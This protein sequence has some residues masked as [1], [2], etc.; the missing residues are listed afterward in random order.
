MQFAE[1]ERYDLT[2]KRLEIIRILDF[3]FSFVLC[4]QEETRTATAKAKARATTTGRT[5]KWEQI[6][7][8]ERESSNQCFSET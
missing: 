5:E 7:R 1:R 6:E 4:F 8:L 3:Y 2:V